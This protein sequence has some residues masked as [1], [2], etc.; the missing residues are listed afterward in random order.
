MMNKEQVI[1]KKISQK[2]SA[3]KFKE[4]LEQKYVKKM[5]CIIYISFDVL[6]LFPHLRVQCWSIWYEI[7]YFK[8]I[9]NL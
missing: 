4:E 3:S 9:W 2:R 1:V 8:I 5:C 7:R 6:F